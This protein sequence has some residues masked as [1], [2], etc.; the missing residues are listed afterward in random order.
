MVFDKAEQKL[1]N[2]KLTQIYGKVADDDDD[3]DDD[4]W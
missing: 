4:G 3:G 2:K 1:K